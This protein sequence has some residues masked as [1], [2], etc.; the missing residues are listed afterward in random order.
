MMINN[1][2]LIHATKNCHCFYVTRTS[3]FVD[4]PLFS[5]QGCSPAYSCFSSECFL[6]MAQ[7]SAA[8][9][10]RASLCYTSI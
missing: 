2:Y 8:N 5:L 1:D 9:Q 3:S 7:N 4:I 6:N 10:N